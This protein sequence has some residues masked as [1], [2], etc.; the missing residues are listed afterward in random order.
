[1]AELTLFVN[2]TDT[3]LLGGSAVPPVAP[4]GAAA[5]S[6]AAGGFAGV[7][8]KQL[9]PGEGVVATESPPQNI[10]VQNVQVSANGEPRPLGGK[11]L[12][13]ATSQNAAHTELN[14]P[15][16]DVS[17]LSAI[18][19]ASPAVTGQPENGL[20][21]TTL[22]LPTGPALVTP[23]AALQPT[24]PQLAQTHAADKGGLPT[25][26]TNPNFPQTSTLQQATNL[27][28]LKIVE[29]T[30]TTALSNAAQDAQRSVVIPAIPSLLGKPISLTAE[31]ALARIHRPAGA[32]NSARAE[33][34]LASS[35]TT[36]NVQNNTAPNLPAG[37]NNLMGSTARMD[38]FSA[39]MGANTDG[40]AEQYLT[41]SPAT[42]APAAL[43]T[44]AILPDSAI[45][46]FADA[47][48]LPGSGFSPTLAVTTPV[49]QPAWASEMG[50]RV[51]WLANSELRQAQ[52]QLH[53]R[54]LGTVEV[55]I[56][57]GP[58]QQL[59]VSFNAT[60]PIARDALEASLP[61]LREM[62]EQQG[63]NLANT[64][65]S[66]ESPDDSKRH[67]NM[68]DELS[69]QSGLQESSEEL[70]DEIDVHQSPLHWLSEGMLDAYA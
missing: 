6:A 22:L 58:E 2:S 4:N 20:A 26:L 8:G 29:P 50:Q 34:L 66:Q 13:L 65:I 23:G 9:K 3:A 17:L 53:P 35:L 38:I 57:Y 10:G 7:L 70:A 42:A 63:L 47:P 59:N 44:S 51:T 41:T 36:I 19:Q 52:L 5:G 67:N 32:V 12:P 69:N 46:L 37:M 16:M 1:M 55:R 48:R 45:N 64:N 68:R 24:L 49:G 40:R 54:N 31:Q 18:A 15:V 21:G 30:T 56:A 33:T 39:A 43:T 27:P 14:H 60:N 11:T 62:F 28:A 25:Q 61:R